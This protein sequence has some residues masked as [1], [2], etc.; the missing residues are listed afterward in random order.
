VVT[1]L[2]L[3]SNLALVGIPVQ[4]SGVVNRAPITGGVHVVAAVAGL[5][6]LLALRAAARP[7]PARRLVRTKAVATRTAW[8]GVFCLG[9][10]VYYTQLQVQVWLWY[11]A[12]LLVWGVVLL[13]SFLLDAC[14]VGLADAKTAGAPGRTLAP[15]FAVLGIPLAVG[16][17]WQWQSF[18]DPDIR[19]IQLANQEAAV[20]INHNLPADALLASWDAG[21][22]GFYADQPVVNLDGVV[23]S[24]EWDRATE[25]GAAAVRRFLD[26]EHVTYIVNHAGA[27]E[28]GDP[29][30]REFVAKVFG[31]E[32]ARGIE[33]VKSFPFTFSGSAVGTSGRS[34]GSRAFAVYIYRIPPPP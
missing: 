13:L 3:A 1:A 32:R 11:F 25:D 19:S 26:D 14:E 27:T 12:P 10:L 7:R 16:L 22:T 5:L 34:S 33:L 4:I 17:V 31:A 8:Y 28:G 29:G 6:G 2:Y 23:N 9:L 18:A 20:W 24:P 21:V 30:V 15:L